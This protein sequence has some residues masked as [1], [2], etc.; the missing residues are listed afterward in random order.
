MCDIYVIHFLR[1]PPAHTAVGLCVYKFGNA[2][3]TEVIK[4]WAE[5]GH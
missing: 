5:G 2:S 4:Q 1:S 3:V